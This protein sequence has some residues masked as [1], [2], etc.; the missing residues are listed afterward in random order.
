MKTKHQKTMHLVKHVFTMAAMA[1]LAG[2]TAS[3]TTSFRT[4]YLGVDI[5]EKGYIV[6][7]WNTTRNDSRNIAHVAAKIGE[8]WQMDAQSVLDLTAENAKRIFNQ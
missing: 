7:M 4:H 1:L 5:N 3:R 8:I 2:C 6:G